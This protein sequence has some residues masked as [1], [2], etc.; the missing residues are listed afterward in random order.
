MSNGTH[1]GY[2]VRWHTD[3]SLTPL[4]HCFLFHHSNQLIDETARPLRRFK[5]LF[6]IAVV[7]ALKDAFYSPAEGAASG[8]LFDFVS[9]HTG[10]CI[11]FGRSLQHNNVSEA[12]SAFASAQ[13][14]PA[15]A[16]A[17]TGQSHAHAAGDSI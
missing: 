11:D 15:R 14:R 13:V 5:L 9:N 17:Q 4:L 3:D 8:R 16:R 7:D 6:K 10:V 2:C 12:S 1:V